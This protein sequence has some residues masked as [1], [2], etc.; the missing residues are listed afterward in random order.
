ML[1]LRPRR[2]SHRARPAAPHPL[3][4]L[5]ALGLLVAASAAS[6]PVASAQPAAAPQTLVDDGVALFRAGQHAE[7]LHHFEQAH[8]SSGDPQVL[9]L[10][11][12]CEEEL[13]HWRVALAAYERFVATADVPGDARGRAESSIRRLRTRL[14]RAR[15]ILQVVPFGARVQVDEREV[16]VAPVEPLDLEPGRH[17]VVVQGPAGELKRL[18][19]ELE[20]GEERTV[21]VQLESAALEAP[22]TSPSLPGGP[23][24]HRA[25]APPAPEP[26]DS[27]GTPGRAAEPRRRASFVTWAALAGAVGLAAGGAVT[28]A[29][30][31]AAHRS[32]TEAHGYGGPGWVGMDYAEATDLEERGDRRKRLGLIL[33]GAGLGLA[34]IGLALALW[35][36]GGQPAAAPRA[37]FGTGAAGEPIAGVAGRF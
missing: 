29:V 24:P 25:A 31:E 27:T 36:E 28:F 10:I 16:G 30:G 33:G 3:L 13:G 34:G 11:A 20:G 17:T 2:S 14:S 1:T 9:Y 12:R 35:P 23:Q 8:R 19:L 15:L 21:A 7:A 4:F 22:E 32:V 5:A 18:E 26:T 6:L 37:W